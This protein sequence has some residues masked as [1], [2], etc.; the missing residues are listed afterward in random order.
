MQIRWVGRSV[1]FCVL[2]HSLVV[3]AGPPT[4]EEAEVGYVNFQGQEVKF[5]K[6][7]PLWAPEG[8]ESLERAASSVSG[9]FYDFLMGPGTS[10]SPTQTRAAE[11]LM[12][13]EDLLGT[14]IKMLTGKELTPKY[15]PYRDVL[16]LI[17]AIKAR[18]ENAREDMAA[19]RKFLGNSYHTLGGPLNASPDKGQYTAR[20]IKDLMDE[21]KKAEAEIER[22]KGYAKSN[23][24]A[25]YDDAIAIAHRLGGNLSA[26][27]LMLVD[28]PEEIAKHATMLRTEVL[29]Q[30]SATPAVRSRVGCPAEFDGL[31][32][33]AM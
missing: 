18:H 16:Y 23:E 3:L 6:D 15:K 25:D 14:R 19:V 5:K 7:L 9:S 24:I 17:K 11:A 21:V 12:S 32:R 29:K 13:G 28:L 22:R 31:V 26:M 27:K 1:I 8:K 10:L 30:T 20:N 33:K 2:A 4:S